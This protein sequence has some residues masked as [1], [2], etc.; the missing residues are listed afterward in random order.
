M[1][2]LALQDDPSVSAL[3]D[4][5]V[6]ARTVARVSSPRFVDRRKE[7][8]AIEAALAQ[9]RDGSGSVVFV[10]GEAGIGKSRLISE[11][12]GRAEGDGMTVLVGECL[13]VRDG[14]L[15]YAPVVGALRSLVA[16]REGTEL[17]AML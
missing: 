10:G 5:E 17:E 2:S 14:K 6:V 11:V 12:A 8:L 13:P 9:A 4:R 16:Q 3:C 7:M 1:L 15:P